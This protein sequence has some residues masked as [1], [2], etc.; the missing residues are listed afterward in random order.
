MIKMH[1]YIPRLAEQAL[2]RGLSRAPALALLGPRQCG[3]S[4]LARQWLGDAPD[5]PR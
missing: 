4:T 3:K 5:L 1:G 2:Q